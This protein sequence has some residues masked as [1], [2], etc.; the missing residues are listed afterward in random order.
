MKKSDVNFENA[1]V[2]LSEKRVF[3]FE[4]P[5]YGILMRNIFTGEFMIAQNSRNVAVP[6]EQAEKIIEIN[7]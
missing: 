2:A 3:C 5:A 1:Y 6:Y 4:P 7:F